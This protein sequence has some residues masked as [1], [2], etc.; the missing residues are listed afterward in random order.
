[1]WMQQGQRCIIWKDIFAT[2]CAM[3]GSKICYKPFKNLHHMK[4]K[5]KS[6]GKEILLQPLCGVESNRKKYARNLQRICYIRRKK[7]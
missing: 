6:Y 4:K 1:M 5:I 2:V 7:G 3:K